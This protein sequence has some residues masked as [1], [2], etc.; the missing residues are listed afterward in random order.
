MATLEQSLLISTIQQAKNNWSFP[1]VVSHLDENGLEVT[2]VLT[3]RSI[4]T[5]KIISGKRRGIPRY[6]RHTKFTARSLLCLDFNKECLRKLVGQLMDENC[7]SIISR[8]SISRL[9]SAV[10]RT[11]ATLYPY[12]AVC[13]GGRDITLS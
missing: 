3:F 8:Q 11:C 10:D 12:C 2:T 13:S 5:L 7:S 6:L 4:S 1:I 9:G